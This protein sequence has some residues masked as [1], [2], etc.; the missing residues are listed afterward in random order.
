MNYA[1]CTLVSPEG[2]RTRYRIGRLRPSKKQPP[3]FDRKISETFLDF[4]SPLVEMMP[5]DASTASIQRVLKIACA[6]WNA[7]I[8]EDV[9]GDDH[10][11]LRLRELMANDPVLDVLATELIGR[12]R[13]IFSD[14]IR[15]IGDYRVTR[16]HGELRL[17]A[18]A[19]DPHTIPPIENSISLE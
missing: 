13:A 12:K 14:D 10:Y 3:C 11:M 1:S 6:V 17:W 15:L 18:E 7:M 19:R 9:K 2:K 4:A 16:K 8:F 5:D